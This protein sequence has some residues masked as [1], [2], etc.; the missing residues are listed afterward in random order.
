VSN[1]EACAKAFGCHACDPMVR[2]PAQ[3]LQLW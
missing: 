3:R 2:P 1:L